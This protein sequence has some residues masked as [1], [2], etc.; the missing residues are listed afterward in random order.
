MLC[1]IITWFDKKTILITMACINCKQPP[2]SEN[3]STSNIGKTKSN[4]RWPC[5]LNDNKHKETLKEQKHDDIKK[6]ATSVCLRNL[7]F[8]VAHIVVNHVTLCY[9]MSYCTQTLNHFISMLDTLHN[10]IPI[11]ILYMVPLNLMPNTV[12]AQKLI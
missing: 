8:I 11:L 5:F 4:F 3:K 12:I 1:L 7:F 2:Y 6:V 10:A 9:P